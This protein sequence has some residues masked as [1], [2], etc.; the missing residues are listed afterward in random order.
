[1]LPTATFTIDRPAPGVAVVTIEGDL[2]AYSAPDLRDTYVDLI[3]EAAFQQVFDLSAVARIDSTGFGVIVGALK[4]L[5]A[6]GGGLA[7]VVPFEA[8]DV[9]HALTIT[10]LAKT[11]PHA[12]TI[13]GALGLLQPEA[14]E[15]DSRPAFWP[16]QVGDVWLGQLDQPSPKA[17]VCDKPGV[18]EGVHR[19]GAEEAWDAYGPLR[20]V[21][22]D[23]A[24][25]TA[26][27]SGEF[28]E[29]QGR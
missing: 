14:D 10:G 25:V 28:A 1:M 2:D 27:H 13:E 21:W 12:E 11:I 19:R 4:N 18:L 22:R 5:R 16:P 29:P 17:W 26:T 20:M 23:G 7:L 8:A 15:L 3:N 9:R 6:R 24:V